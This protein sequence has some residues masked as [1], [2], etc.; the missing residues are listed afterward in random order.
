MIIDMF[1]MSSVQEKCKK[2]DSGHETCFLHSMDTV[3]LLCH[4]ITN[5]GPFTGLE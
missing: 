3:A 2:G 5:N 4:K 1:F